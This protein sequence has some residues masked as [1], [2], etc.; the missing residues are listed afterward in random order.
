M[1]EQISLFDYVQSKE[2]A[3]TKSRKRGSDLPE[4]VR[5][6]IGDKSSKDLSHFL[7]D[8]SGNKEILLVMHPGS[9]SWDDTY[10][11][12]LLNDNV[13]KET[14]VPKDGLLL[15][16]KNCLNIL[17]D[18]GYSYIGYLLYVTDSGDVYESEVTI[19]GKEHWDHNAYRR[20]PDRFVLDYMSLGSWKKAKL[21]PHEAVTIVNEKD[22]DVIFNKVNPYGAQYLQDHLS[23][24]PESNLCAVD[25]MIAP[26]IEQLDKAGYKFVDTLIYALDVH[27]IEVTAITQFQR[28]CQPGKNMKEIF[29]T[30]KAVYTTLKDCKDLCTWDIYRKMDKQG[31]I[32]ASNIQ[33]IYL[34]GYSE[35]DLN[36]MSAI[37]NRQYNGKKI[38]TWD[39]LQKYL[40]RIDMYEA[41]SKWEGLTL[42]KDYLQMCEQLEMKPRID[43]DSL[44]REHDVTARTLRQKHDE[45]RA[46]KMEEIC[47]ENKKYDYSEHIYFGRCVRSYDDLIDEATQQ[48]NCVASYADSITNEHCYIFV[49][50]EVA[51]PDKSLATVE[52]TPDGEIRQKFLA[53]NRPIRNKSLTEF[54]DRLTKNFL[55]VKKNS[56]AIVKST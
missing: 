8:F 36:D 39:S 17:H 52:I 37:L 4:K 7:S 2:K 23:K 48:H 45:I 22:V 53:Y 16:D 46:K 3:K 54:I 38:F 15:D 6:F 51:S 19:T 10:N 27:S 30:S 44:K 40:E 41:I 42:L 21:H 32:D 14:F 31:K 9:R 56:R 35:R 47:E 43:G 20:I 25:L 26:Q 50:R 5:N 12:V 34:A 24:K 13:T 18:S 1:E 29:K 49:V 55:S 11:M 33:R 28:L